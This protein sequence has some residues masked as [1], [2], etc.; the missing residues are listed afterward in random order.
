MPYNEWEKSYVGTRR[1]KGKRDV[2]TYFPRT[3]SP[4]DIIKWCESDGYRVIG[5]EITET[6]ENEKHHATV[7]VNVESSTR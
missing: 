4:I 2:V 1:E 5:H 3:T 6:P 7:V